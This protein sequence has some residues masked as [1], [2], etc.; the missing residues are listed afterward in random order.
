MY[1]TKSSP[2]PTYFT[3]P[4]LSL[5]IIPKC[6]PVGPKIIVTPLIGSTYDQ[7]RRQ[8]CVKGG[9]VRYVSVGGLEYEV[10]HSQLYCLCINV[11]L[12]STALQCICRVIRRSSMA[13][14]AHTYYI[15]FGRPP[16][17]GEASPPSPLA[18]PLHTI[19][20][21]NVLSFFLRIS[22]V[23]EHCLRRSYDFS[24]ESY[25]RKVSRSS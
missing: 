18:A 3:V 10:P 14:K 13:M 19:V 5:F 6:L 2:L 8:D 20:I 22:Q 17:G 16:I 1:F 7:W 21:S 23:Y 25:L 15:I 12:C 11:V 4:D 24:S 9:E